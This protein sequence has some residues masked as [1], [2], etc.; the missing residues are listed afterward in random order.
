[1]ELTLTH[2]IISNLDEIVERLL[3]NHAAVMVGAGF[4]M[5]A[6]KSSPEVKRFP[7]WADLGDAFY[8]KVN[9]ELHSQGNDRYLNALKLAEEVQAQFGRIVLDKILQQEIPDKKYN[10]S[11][12]HNK[13]LQL[14]WNDVFTTNYD[15]LLERASQEVISRKYD[16][17]VKNEDLV[18]SEKPR[19]IKLHGS[20]PSQ[21]PFIITEEDYR[22]YPTMFAPFVNTVQQSLLENALCLIGFSGNDPNFLAWIGW[23]RD[24]LGKENSSKLYLIG[25]FDFSSAQRMLLEKRNIIIIDFSECTELG[26]YNN[27]HELALEAFLDYLLE[28]TK[29]KKEFDWLE[30]EK[31][32][33]VNFIKNA[34]IRDIIKVWTET[35]NTY[36]GWWILPEDLR[37]RLW[38]RT[39]HTLLR[40]VA[41]LKSSKVSQTSLDRRTYEEY[42]DL[43]YLYEY[44]WR[45]EKCL[46]PLCLD[47]VKIY[48]EVIRKYNP[49]PDKLK[50]EGAYAL[51]T[52]HHSVKDLGEKW[53]ALQLALLR[54]FRENND[55]K[56]LNEISDILSQLH[57]VLTPEQRA[58]FNYEKCLKNLFCIRF[59]EI[60]DCLYEWKEDNM[61]PIWEAKRASIWAI[62]GE[63]EIACEIIGKALAEVRK[64]LMLVPVTNNYTMVSQEASL[65]FLSAYYQQA[66]NLK[67]RK[68]ENVFSDSYKERSAEH[69]KYKCDPF[70]EKRIFEIELLNEYIPRA[71]KSVEHTFDIGQVVNHLF[72]NYDDSALLLGLELLRYLEES[73]IPVSVGNVSYSAK[74]MPNVL[75]RISYVNPYLTMIYTILYGDK[76]NTKYIFSRKSISEMDYTEVDNLCYSF[77]QQLKLSENEIKI[78]D[79][80]YTSNFGIRL[81]QILPEVLSRLCVKCSTQVKSKIAEFIYCVY[82]GGYPGKYDK[83]NKLMERLIKTCNEKDLS[84]ILQIFINIPVNS[85]EEVQDILTDPFIYIDN[86]YCNT[87]LKTEIKMDPQ[88]IQSLIASVEKTSLE[89]ENA[90]VRLTVLWKNHLLTADQTKLFAEALWSKTE[91][92]S[93]FPSETFILNTAVFLE[94]PSPPEYNLED[95]LKQY[96]L[97]EIE[98]IQNENEIILQAIQYALRSKIGDTYLCNWSK[99]E[100]FR[101]LESSFQYYLTLRYQP[102]NNL[103]VEFSAF[104]EFCKYV[105]ELIN[106]WMDILLQQTAITDISE[107]KKQKLI[108]IMNELEKE[109]IPCSKLKLSCKK[110]LG[111]TEN[112]YFEKIVRMSNSNDNLTIVDCFDA[113]YYYLLLNVVDKAEGSRLLSVIT[114]QIVTRRKESLFAALEIM[115]KILKFIPEYITEELYQNILCGLEYLFEE[116]QMSRNDSDYLV[117][118]RSQAMGLAGKLYYNCIKKG[119]KISS[120][121]ELWKTASDSSN[122]FWEVRNAWLGDDGAD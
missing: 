54:Y 38:R 91:E 88:I 118:I 7:S 42:E 73:G 102:E 28:A 24:N 39:D 82:T 105:R 5:N 40:E 80:F 78:G 111:I 74:I 20:F 58:K 17:I 36:P 11:K 93:G 3:S 34:D 103:M 87:T 92:V 66:I 100:R 109:E 96:L 18:Y 27:K 76:K 107:D 83:L 114:C 61:M 99:E 56:K 52:I 47:Q 57:E 108:L 51:T 113:I 75:Q 55:I 59:N 72:I 13:L 85:D 77:L 90:I 81:A 50:I 26:R 15:T 14:P 106:L 112:N 8:K 62:L 104:D 53:I 10:P 33:H 70:Q 94:L 60:K 35:R 30:G 19:I 63:V 46:I 110:V 32:F 37:K 43:L 71:E 86:Y 121:L 21:R 115:N 65:M 122:E 25:V 12:L 117:G 95:R 29:K 23:I 120:V 45:Q 4:S 48:E 6:L 2:D 9:G 41:T 1:M 64:Q 101:L 98:N 44:N 116:S 31:E 69:K 84:E 67:F 119:W 49:F 97:Q 22:I 68:N 89:R 16:V 79:T